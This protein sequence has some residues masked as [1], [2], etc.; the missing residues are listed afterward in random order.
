MRRNN[1]VRNIP[2]RN[3]GR[4]VVMNLDYELKSMDQSRLRVA[5]IHFASL[6]AEAYMYRVF[7]EGQN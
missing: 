1:I 7:Q 5:V 3:A 6:E 4:L 2:R